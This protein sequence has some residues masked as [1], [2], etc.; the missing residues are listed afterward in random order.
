[1]GFSEQRGVWW[2][3]NPAPAP[4]LSTCSPP[5]QTETG[6]T[7][8]SEQEN[9]GCQDLVRLAH[10]DTLGMFLFLD[11]AQFSHLKNATCKTFFFPS[12]Y[13]SP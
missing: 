4:A 10:L 5:C 9:P 3:W 8:V 2:A 6:S 7:R 1:M 12:L 11:G 13:W